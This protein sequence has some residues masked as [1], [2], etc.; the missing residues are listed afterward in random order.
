[1]ELAAAVGVTP[2]QEEALRRLPRDGD[3][4]GYE[5]ARTREPVWL[6]SSE[7]MHARYPDMAL[8]MGSSQA[9]AFL[10]LLVEGKVLGVI[11]LGFGTPRRFS[12]L[13]QASMLGLARQ[14]GLAL[15]R[16]LLYEREHA[17]RLQAE[18][19]G[20]R[21]RL[22]ADASALLSRSLEWKETVDGRG[23]PGPGHLRGLVRGGRDHG[24]ADAPGD[25]AARGSLP[26]RW[27]PRSSALPA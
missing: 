17:A 15:E 22:L 7:E 23:A 10:P 8:S 25:R 27:R 18:A 24:G 13:E 2:E 14:C 12:E 5:A 21:M 4:P 3:M 1:M 9:S 26:R 16:S 11:A 6:K 20:Q 19:A